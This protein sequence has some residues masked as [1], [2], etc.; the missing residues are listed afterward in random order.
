MQE[1]KPC[2]EELNDSASGPDKVHNYLVKHLPGEALRLLLRLYNDIWTSGNF[3]DTWRL[4]TVI[5]L[6]TP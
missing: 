1:L 4:A 3:P 5:P 2:V 6:P